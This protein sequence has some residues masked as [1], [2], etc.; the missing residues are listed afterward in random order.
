MTVESNGSQKFDRPQGGF[1]PY[2]NENLPLCS[3][4]TKSRMSC[5]NPYVRDVLVP[6]EK[7]DP[8]EL[9]IPERVRL[10]DG[11]FAE[12]MTGLKHVDGVDAGI[13]QTEDEI[14][15]PMICEWFTSKNNG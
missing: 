3:M 4:C 11:S 9:E 12:N 13:F 1:V 5:D 8:R 6:L 14:P 15:I 10:V 7:G 2:G